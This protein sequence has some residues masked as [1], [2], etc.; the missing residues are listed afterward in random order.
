MDDSEVELTADV[1]EIAT[2]LEL[3]VEPED[4]TELPEPHDTVLTDELLLM[5]EQKKSG[6]WR[7][8]LPLV[9]ML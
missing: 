4:V 6:F 9:K 7:W 2:E 1:V 3:K 5:N 8:N